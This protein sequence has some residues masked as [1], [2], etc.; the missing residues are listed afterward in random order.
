M[1]K[2][3]DRFAQKQKIKLK[4]HS[5]KRKELERR[6]EKLTRLANITRHQ[7]RASTNTIPADATD[8]QTKAHNLLTKMSQFHNKTDQNRAKNSINT[9]QTDAK[10][11]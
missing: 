4:G 6:K 11:Q 7:L 1:A 9:M 3:E 2:K 5:E 10:L 8:W